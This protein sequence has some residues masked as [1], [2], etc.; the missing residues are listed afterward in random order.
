MRKAGRRNTALRKY[1]ATNMTEAFATAVEC[2]FEQPLKLKTRAPDLYV[3]LA[4]YLNQDPAAYDERLITDLS[5]T[6]TPIVREYI[7]KLLDGADIREGKIFMHAQRH[8]RGE[9]SL[10]ACYRTKHGKWSKHQS[11]DL[12][13]MARDL[14]REPETELPVTLELRNGQ[15]RRLSAWGEFPPL[16]HKDMDKLLVTLQAKLPNAPEGVLRDTITLAWR[17]YQP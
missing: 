11:A 15:I 3:L 16:L 6:V 17:A 12:Y 2:F 8:H 10:Y 7:G 4:L 9:P 14:P 5:A 13:L 1:G